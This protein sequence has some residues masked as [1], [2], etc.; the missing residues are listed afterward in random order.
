[1]RLSPFT[2]LICLGLAACGSTAPE[3]SPYLKPNVLMEQEINS[4]IAQVP[5]QQR[6]ELFN[7]LLWLAQTGEQAIPALLEA[8]QHQNPKVRSNCLWVLGRIRDRRAI[9]QIVP[10][11]NDPDETVRLEAARTLV[12][13]GDLSHVP[14][15]IEGLDSNKLQ[16]RYLCH[17]ALRQSTGRNFGYDHLDNDID[18]RR[19]ATYRWRKWWSDQSGDP[20]F[21][22]D[23]AADYEIDVFE[24][25]NDWLTGSAPAPMGE[26]Q[27]MV[28]MAEQALP[29]SPPLTPP[30]PQPETELEMG[31]Q[32]DAPQQPQ[33]EAETLETDPILPSSKPDED[34]ADA[35]KNPFQPR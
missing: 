25:E 10:L 21:A 8:L 29:E 4:R 9:E 28:D 32:L 7:N 34:E 18:S 12:T 3:Q 31:E 14:L 1:M 2:A 30:E 6:E 19:L 16:V 11:V 27:P 20:W 33:P 13:M 22:K 15:L 17:E 26:T 24:A 35:P 23:Y 5:F